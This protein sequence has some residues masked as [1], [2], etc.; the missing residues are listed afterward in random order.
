MAKHAKKRSLKK[1]FLPLVTTAAA[2]ATI[3]TTPII[4][5][6]PAHAQDGCKPVEVLD[7]GG[8]RPAPHPHTT[9]DRVQ[10]EYG[11]VANVHRLDYPASAGAMHSLALPGVGESA[12]TYQDSRLQGVENAKSH[13]QQVKRDCPGTKFIIMGY[14]QGA[15]VAGDV[16]AVVAHGGVPG[17]SSNDVLGTVTL[18]DPSRGGTS[19]FAGPSHSTTGYLPIPEGYVYQRNGGFAPGNLPAGTAGMTG[20]KTLDYGDLAGRFLTFCHEGDPVCVME[21]NNPAIM[22]L[23]RFVNSVDS[24]TDTERAGK[25]AGRVMVEQPF[26][27]TQLVTRDIVPLLFGDNYHDAFNRARHTIDTSIIPDL[28]KKLLTNV[29]DEM[30]TLF[31]ILHSDDMYGEHMSD[32]T[33]MGHILFRAIPQVDGSLEVPDFLKQPVKDVLAFVLGGHNNAVPPEVQERV[34]PIIDKLVGFPVHHTSYWRDNVP[35]RTTGDIIADTII[36]G[37]MNYINGTPYTV[38]GDPNNHGEP[39]ENYHDDGLRGVVDGVERTVHHDD[40]TFTDGWAYRREQR[41]KEREEEEREKDWQK[42]RA[43]IRED[44]E[45]YQS[46]DKLAHGDKTTDKDAENKNESEKDTATTTSP[47]TVSEG[48]TGGDGEVTNDGEKVSPSAVISVVDDKA[49][50]D[51]PEP[52][53]VLPSATPETPATAV[54]TTVT[55]T[56]N[57]V[58]SP[59]S[60]AD[61]SSIAGKDSDKDSIKGVDKDTDK[62]STKDSTQDS[63]K[64]TDKDSTKG[65]DKDTDKGVD[66]DTSSTIDTVVE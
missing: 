35:G 8:T 12:N 23:V 32:A 15:S 6:A 65:V 21:K 44:Q 38:F 2:T 51:D 64:D 30:D 34:N 7:I 66:K 61:V 53:V 22:Q 40:R 27:A 59:T 10:R 42:F 49:R 19:Q 37:I 41:E 36:R 5:I 4:T 48:S 57:D 17:V 47:S 1:R 55:P 62:G 63:T 14:S 18:A 33:I 28:D 56:V 43:S 25:T 29:F 39:S 54:V 26:M 24:P 13:M 16:T 3:I 60:D 11:H 52:A 20:D 45:R 31:D 46:W 58:P 50:V 9:I